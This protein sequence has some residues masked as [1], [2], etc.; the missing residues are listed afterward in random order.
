MI[1]LPSPG[2]R[3]HVAV[4]PIRVGCV[5]LPHDSCAFPVMRMA[6]ANG[7][8]VTAG[9]QHLKVS[10]ARSKRTHSISGTLLAS[11]LLVRGICQNIER[12][13]CS[14]ET[15][16][17]WRSGLSMGLGCCSLGRACHPTVHPCLDSSLDSSNS[18][19]MPIQGSKVPARI[20]A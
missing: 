20:S 4:P 11:G 18:R 5:T 19:Y 16:C 7:A 1:P 3:T 14:W 8:V 2:H 10:S 13:L 9:C 15:G 12:C 17:P 6:N